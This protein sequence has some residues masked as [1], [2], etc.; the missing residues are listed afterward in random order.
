VVGSRLDHVSTEGNTTH[1]LRFD[2]EQRFVRKK[3]VYVLDSITNE[4]ETERE[5]KMQ[6]GEHMRVTKMIKMWLIHGEFCATN[7]VNK[8]LYQPTF[9]QPFFVILAGTSFRRYTIL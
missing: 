1:P 4:K 8:M 2:I 6:E 5:A 7:Y 3:I 9:Q